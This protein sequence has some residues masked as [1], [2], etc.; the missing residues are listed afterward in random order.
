MTELRDTPSE[1]CIL[2]ERATMEVSTEVIEF[3]S[4]A[5]RFDDFK[6]YV[7]GQDDDEHARTIELNFRS[8]DVEAFAALLESAARFYRSRRP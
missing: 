2:F 1:Y 7:H 8:T 3:G 5:E 6:L 4:D